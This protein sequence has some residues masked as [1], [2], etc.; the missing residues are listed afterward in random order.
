MKTFMAKNETITRKWY[1]VDAEG[2]TLG[3]L[4]TQVASVLRGKDKPIYT[5]NVDCGDYVIV[6]NA[7]KIELTGNKWLDKKYYSHSG[8]YGGLKTISARD[9]MKKHPTQ[10]V[11]KAVLGMLPKT[12]LGRQMGTKLFVY[13]EAEHKHEAQKPEKLE[14]K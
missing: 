2:Q 13:K 6:V 14:L 7:D 3:R 5:P 4:A 9:L 8:Y 12:K 11:K 1:V 10:M